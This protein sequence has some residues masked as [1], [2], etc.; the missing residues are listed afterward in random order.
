M[1]IPLTSCPFV[2]G[3]NRHCNVKSII[4]VGR[5]V[6]SNVFCCMSMAQGKGVNT[7]M[8][9]FVGLVLKSQIRLT[10]CK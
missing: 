7:C 10:E 4:D 9:L 2:Y 8:V 6:L 5:K 1:I 3:I